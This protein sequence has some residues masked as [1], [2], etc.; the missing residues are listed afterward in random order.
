MMVSR[1]ALT[2]VGEGSKQRRAC[3]CSTSLR[4]QHLERSFDVRARERRT[5]SSCVGQAQ[6]E[7][8]DICVWR[9]E[10]TPAAPK[11]RRRRDGAEGAAQVFEVLCE[12]PAADVSDW[13]GTREGSSAWDRTGRSLVKRLVR[14][15]VDGL[16]KE[17]GGGGRKPAREPSDW[18]ARPEI[19]RAHAGGDEDARRRGGPGPW[20]EGGGRSWACWEGCS[21]KGAGGGCRRLARVVPGRPLTSL[22]AFAC[23]FSPQ[24]PWALASQQPRADLALS[25]IY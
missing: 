14:E 23:A 10:G 7:L 20:P 21:V 3:A 22:R 8:Q 9:K 24:A 12:G 6:V 17:R 5:L 15:K 1:R 13:P 2:D 25:R 4:D 18:I 19:S 16:G 11:E